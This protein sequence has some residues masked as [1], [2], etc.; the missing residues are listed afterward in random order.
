MKVYAVIY[1]DYESQSVLGVCQRKCSAF[2]YADMYKQKFPQWEEYV[3]VCSYEV[4]DYFVES[5]E[6]I[7]PE[8]SPGKE[9][10]DG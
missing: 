10:C 3:H 4:K 2:L 8:G 5:I 7:Q 6:D 1:D 9:R